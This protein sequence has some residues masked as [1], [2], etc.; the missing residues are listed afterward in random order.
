MMPTKAG[1]LLLLLLAPSLALFSQAG[2]APADSTGS[3]ARPFEIGDQTISL[4]VGV[5]IPLFTFGGDSTSFD[6]NINPGGSFSFTYQYFI[7]PGFSLGGSLAG[8]FNKTVGDRTLFMAPLSFRTAYWWILDPF[9]FSAAVEVGAY[10]SR[11]SGEGMMG[12]FAKLGGGVYWR[13]SNGWSIG[14]QP[15]YWFVPEIH[16]APY[17]NLTRFGNFFE[18]SISATYHL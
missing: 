9:E 14:V 18:T 13:V 4:S 2:A 3:G 11:I 17:A 1:A 10:I 16:A 8:S 15:Y 6:P 5:D 12:P 7:S